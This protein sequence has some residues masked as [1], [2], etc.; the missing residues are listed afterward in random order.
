[1]DQ[2][3]G[4]VDESTASLKE[5]MRRPRWSKAA[6]LLMTMP[7][8]GL[9]TALTIL[10]ELG[11]L[12]RFRNRAAVANYAGLAPVCRSSND[13]RYSRG[14]YPSRLEAFASRVGRSRLDGRISRTG[15]PCHVRADRTEEE[16]T[17]SHHC[18]GE[19]NVGG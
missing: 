2:I 11:D 8:T 12:K 6:A 5:L 18:C 7:G 17:R 15:L 1:M 10:M 16:Q 19:T 9:I 13:K 4:A 3:H 14:D